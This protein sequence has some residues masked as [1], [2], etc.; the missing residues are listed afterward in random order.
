MARKKPKKTPAPE[1]ASARV[2]IG[3][4]G[5]S[6]KPSAWI[7]QRT[8][9]EVTFGAKVYDDDIDVAVAKAHAAYN[10]IVHRLEEDNKRRSLRN[11]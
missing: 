7:E 6:G 10:S 3:I 11:Q 8:R 5:I 2:E 9:G 1:P 4:E